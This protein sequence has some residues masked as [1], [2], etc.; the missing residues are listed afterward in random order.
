MVASQ[1]QTT[2]SGAVVSE[3]SG[4]DW[5]DHL[6]SKLNRFALATRLA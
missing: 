4:S 6:N 3:G 1:N 5:I 2:A